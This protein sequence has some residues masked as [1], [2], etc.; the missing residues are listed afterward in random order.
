M[1]CSSHVEDGTVDVNPR[2]IKVMFVCDEWKSLKGGLSTLNRQ[3]AINVAKTCSNI[4]VYCYVAQGDEKDK[5]DARKNGVTLFTAEKLPGNPN[6]HDWLKFPPPDLPNPDVVVGHGRKFGPVAYFIVRMANC[7]WVQVLHVFCPDL[8]K[9]KS[10]KGS[11]GLRALDPIDDNEEKHHDEIQLSQSADAV[12]AVGTKLL[13]KYR[14][15]L[16]NTTIEVI[17]PGIL[18]N[19]PLYEPTD[20]RLAQLDDDEVFDI[21]VCGRAAYEDRKLK[22]YDIAAKAVAS[23]GNMFRLTFVGSQSGAQKKLEKWFRKEAKIPK[24]R[25]TICR[26]MDQQNLK[27]MFKTQDLFVLPSREESFGMGAL[28]ALSSGIP[29]LVSKNTG[30]ADALRKVEGG[31]TVIVADNDFEEWAVRIQQLSCQTPR[32][33]YEN[34]RRLRE[35]YLKTYPWEQECGRFA[36]VIGSLTSEGYQNENASSPLSDKGSSVESASHEKKRKDSN[37]SEDSMPI[38][39]QANL[40]KYISQIFGKRSP[41]ESRCMRWGDVSL[42]RHPETGSETLVW[43]G[44]DSKTPHQQPERD[45]R[46]QSMAVGCYKTF[47]SHRPQEMKDPG[48][49]FFLRAKKRRKE[50]DP[51]WYMKVPKGVK[52]IAEMRGMEKPHSV[53]RSKNV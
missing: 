24:E 44:P 41:T 13:R 38:M 39:L 19:F 29:V 16:P 26:Y 4:K 8:G 2:P 36:T 20:E 22:G 1:A 11:D 15:V 10:S 51:V 3:L 7:K 28:E 30:I 18:E 12:L 32:E 40:D 42:T 50:G 5:E 48:S 53:L 43:T 46:L 21:L 47:C 33:R 27:E 6:R 17:T 23:L 49:P 14:K 9:Y 45:E 52:K 31:D 25:L 34:A 37:D 35:N